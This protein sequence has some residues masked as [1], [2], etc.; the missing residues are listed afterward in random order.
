MRV[1]RI[2]QFEFCRLRSETCP[3]E[4][5]LLVGGINR[6]HRG[7]GTASN[8]LLREGTVATANIE[9]LK[10]F[11]KVEPAEE[12][13]ACKTAPTAHHPLVG[14]SVSEKLSFVHVD[15]PC[16]SEGAFAALYVRKPVAWKMSRG[17]DTDVRFVPEADMCQCTSSCLRWAKGRHI[18]CT[19]STERGIAEIDR[20]HKDLGDRPAIGAHCV[21]ATFRRQLD[22]SAQA[23]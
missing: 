1:L 2:A 23:P 16:L 19:K 15:P 12:S 4:G 5:E 13:F 3:R 7:R 14:F 21:G 18:T 20:D 22:P 17:S 11:W 6:H 8:N 10:A 9:P